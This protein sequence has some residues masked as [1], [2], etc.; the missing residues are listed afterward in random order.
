M[1]TEK[2]PVTAEIIL[3]IRQGTRRGFGVY[4]VK[5]EFLCGGTLVEC[6]DF[7]KRETDEVFDPS[8]CDHITVPREDFVRGLE[9]IKELDVI[10]RH[11]DPNTLKIAARFQH[12]DDHDR[13]EH[14]PD[15]RNGVWNVV[16]NVVGMRGRS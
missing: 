14:A 5:G 4:N 1:D 6:Q 12:G 13:F 15:Q 3:T 11:I 9:S 8:K 7:I 16:Q 10:K 2:T